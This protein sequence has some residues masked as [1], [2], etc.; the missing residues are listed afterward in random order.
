MLLCQQRPQII[1]A[2]QTL[3]WAVEVK[4][5]R[6][7]R[8]GVKRGRNHRGFDLPAGLASLNQNHCEI[9]FRYRRFGELK[10]E[11]HLSGLPTIRPSE[12]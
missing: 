1:A 9:T 11:G 4:K 7:A 10:V 12:R 3:E 6:L 2:I 5:G 8:E